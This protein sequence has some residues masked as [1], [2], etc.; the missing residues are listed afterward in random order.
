MQSITPKIEKKLQSM[1][2][3]KLYAN[4]DLKLLV[5]LYGDT[6]VHQ[7][8]LNCCLVSLALLAMTLLQ[9][10][11]KNNQFIHISFKCMCWTMRFEANK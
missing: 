1:E 4:V 5:M 11:L 10:I 6:L 7:N 2:E 3:Q 9:V 8:T